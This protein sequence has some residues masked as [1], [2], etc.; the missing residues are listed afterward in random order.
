MDYIKAFIVKLRHVEL[1]VQFLAH[2]RPVCYKVTEWA[3]KRVNIGGCIRLNKNQTSSHLIELS[4]GLIRRRAVSECE[5]VW[6][7]VERA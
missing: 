1:Y 6:H 7:L 2:F 4:T 5:V 3:C